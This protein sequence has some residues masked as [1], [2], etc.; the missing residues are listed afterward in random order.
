[1]GLINGAVW[2]YSDASDLIVGIQRTQ[3]IYGMGG[4]D[5]IFSHDSAYANYDVR[6]N[7][8]FDLAGLYLTVLGRRPDDAGFE[9]FRQMLARDQITEEDLAGAIVGS[10][11]ALGWHEGLEDAEY[12]EALYSRAF[13]RTAAETEIDSWVSLM[14]SGAQDRA[15]VAHR[16]VTSTEFRIKNGGVQAEYTLAAAEI[17]LADDV[18][19]AYVSLL[20]RPPGYNDVSRWTWYATNGFELDLMVGTLFDSAEFASTAAPSLPFLS[21]LPR[22]PNV[23]FVEADE[24]TGQQFVGYLYEK[25]LGRTAALDEVSAWVDIGNEQFLWYTDVAL[26]IL[27]SPEANARHRLDY[28]VHMQG[29]EGDALVG[30]PG[31]NMM[32]GGPLSDTF[33]FDQADAGTHRIL[34]FSEIDELRFVGFDYVDADAVLAQFRQVGAD[35]VLNDQ[36]T[37]VVLMNTDVADI[38]VWAFELA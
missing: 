2:T 37:Q 22:F 29:Q 6:D 3:Q 14:A 17:D 18:Y 35:A 24:A 16:I 12:V 34:E 5:L 26:M 28:V 19:R 20:E 13:G 9:G 1:M 30:G 31:D 11:E 23:R 10:V 15:S 8:L 21:D 38:P 33:V 27:D 36:D 32:M 25:V 4:D 7:I